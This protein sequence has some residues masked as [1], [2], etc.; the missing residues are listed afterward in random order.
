[1]ESSSFSQREPVTLDFPAAFR[2]L[3]SD[4]RHAVWYWR[5]RIQNAIM[6]K[7]EQAAK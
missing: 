2:A 3:Y 7:A 6:L 4:G 1:M 5:R